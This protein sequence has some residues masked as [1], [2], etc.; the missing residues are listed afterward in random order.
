MV[1]NQ[2]IWQG[3]M[4]AMCLQSI[5]IADMVDAGCVSQAAASQLACSLTLLTQKS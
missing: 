3:Q 2:T 1:G 4:Q 5:L